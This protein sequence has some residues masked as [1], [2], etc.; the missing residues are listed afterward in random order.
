M[1]LGLG[2]IAAHGVFGSP[3][4]GKIY[5][6][7]PVTASGLIHAERKLLLGWAW[8]RTGRRCDHGHAPC[9][10]SSDLACGPPRHFKGGQSRFNQSIAKGR[11]QWMGS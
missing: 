10:R 1:S 6:S 3:R 9:R 2:V 4:G 5:L 11:A 7:R 8:K